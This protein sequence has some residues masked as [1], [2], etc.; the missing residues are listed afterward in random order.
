MSNL[1]INYNLKKK[2]FF[3]YEICFPFIFR[4]E[5]EVADFDFGASEEVISWTLPQ[6]IKQEI[7]AKFKRNNYADDD[8]D[9]HHK[10]RPRS[11]PV[12]RPRVGFL[13]NYGSM[14]ERDM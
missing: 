3:I 6:R 5:V 9:D 4:Y 10:W 7:L 8:A 11:N 13:T 1:L 2:N 14:N 12:E